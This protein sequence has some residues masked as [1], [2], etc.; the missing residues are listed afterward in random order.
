MAD[1]KPVLGLNF[2]HRR[3]TACPLVDGE[4]SKNWKAVSL[5]RCEA[6]GHRRWQTCAGLDPRVDTLPALFCL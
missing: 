3:F 4:E 1:G 6:V 5:I 2:R